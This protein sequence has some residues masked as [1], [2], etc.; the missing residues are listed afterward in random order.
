M[1]HEMSQERGGGGGGTA[2]DC[3]ARDK[4]QGGQA[5]AAAAAAVTLHAL[6]AALINDK[7]YSGEGPKGSDGRPVPLLRA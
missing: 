5:A 7:I 4:M 3:S 2:G 6:L 1:S